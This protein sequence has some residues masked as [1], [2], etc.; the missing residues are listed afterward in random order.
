MN[1]DMEIN[2]W[3][4][5]RA[6]AAGYSAIVLTADALGPGQSDEFIKLGTSLRSDIA[7][8]WIC[9]ALCRASARRVR[10]QSARSV[11]RSASGLLGMAPAARAN[12]VLHQWER[13]LTPSITW[14]TALNRLRDSLLRDRLSGGLSPPWSRYDREH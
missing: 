8:R 4:V 3:L 1:R 13:Q 6:K 12:V 2:R 7:P 14:V 11:I 5:Q 10:R 9:G